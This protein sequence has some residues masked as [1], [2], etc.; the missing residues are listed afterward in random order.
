LHLEDDSPGPGIPD[1]GVIFDNLLPH[2]VGRRTE[3][4]TMRTA[5]MIFAATAITLTACG[6]G[7]GGGRDGAELV[8]Q[9]GDASGF[10][11]PDGVAGAAGMS[12]RGRVGA[13]ASA[14]APAAVKVEVGAGVP[15]SASVTPFQ[16][17]RTQLKDPAPS[18]IIRTAN[19]SIEVD[20]L[21]RA[22]AELRS[23][24]MRVGGYV[25]NTL[26]QG[27]ETQL[28][29]ATIEVKIPSNRFEEVRTGL[30]ALGELKGLNE[31]A[32]DIGEE[33]VDI[34]AR[35]ENS[36]RLEDRLLA[37]LA[38][39]TGR[40]EEVLSVERELAR[41][42]QE[43]E[44]AEGRLRYLSS[45]VSFSTLSISLFEP[46]PVIQHGGGRGVIAEAF[47]QAWRNFVGFVAAIIAALGILIPLGAL[48]GVA[49]LGVNAVRRRLPATGA[50]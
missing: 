34:A 1:S 39:R 3:E 41:V 48:A 14:P 12:A 26:M 8:G 15:T 33:Y 16:F 42:R 19:A 20:S 40:L 13:L 6:R 25:S 30:S 23:L 17:S 50:N 5:M 29:E 43:I 47:A 38:S 2:R 32:Q 4:M 7:P 36:R 37:L 18:M 10:P 21:D 9:A 46:R 31:T 44:R 45:R 22:I 35:V 24:T 28:R 27:G 11:A 49:W